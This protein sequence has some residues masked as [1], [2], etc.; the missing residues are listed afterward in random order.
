ME[1]TPNSGRHGGTGND[2]GDETSRGSGGTARDAADD[3]SALASEHRVAILR[4]LA[5]AD[6]PLTFSELRER[7]GMRDTGRFNYHLGELRGRFVRERDGGYVLGHAGERVVLA[8]ADLDPDGA[9][10]LAEG[11]TGGGGGDGEGACPVCGE[12]DCGRTIHV[13]LDG[14]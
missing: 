9:A 1:F 3:L 5:A 6:A 11:R 13:H 14:R 7:V 2:D 10:T 8:A 4:E 12:V